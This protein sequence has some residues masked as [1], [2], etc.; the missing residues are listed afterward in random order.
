MFSGAFCFAVPHQCLECRKFLPD[1]GGGRRIECLK[2]P[3][4]SRRIAQIDGRLGDSAEIGSSAAEKCG[5]P[6]VQRPFA[7]GCP[8]GLEIPP[9]ADL[10]RKRT[11][12]PAWKFRIAVF[13][14]KF[15]LSG[16]D[17]TSLIVQFKKE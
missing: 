9:A 7:E 1:P 8:A 12:A 11:N 2:P 10:G 4:K 14:E 17:C 13:F 16:L 5:T 3:E 6:A 15:L